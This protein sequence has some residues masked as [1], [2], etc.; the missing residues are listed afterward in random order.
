MAATIRPGPRTPV[1]AELTKH[2]AELAA[3]PVAELFA[4]DPG[5]YERLSRERAG[6]LVDFSRQRLD[7]IALAKL[8]QPADA[9][10]PRARLEA[11]WHG[12][13]INP[14]PDPAAPPRAPR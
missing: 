2:A 12:E 5:R 3:V 11:M 8:A 1:W 10:D 14:S 13:H 9:V 7:E 4:R 6:L